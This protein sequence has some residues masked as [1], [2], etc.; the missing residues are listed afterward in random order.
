MPVAVAYPRVRQLCG[1]PLALPVASMHVAL[2]CNATLPLT[3]VTP[4]VVTPFL[5][6]I[7]YPAAPLRLRASAAA[8][9]GG[10]VGPVVPPP[11]AAP[12]KTSNSAVNPTGSPLCLND[13]TTRKYV[14]SGRPWG[15]V[16]TTAVGE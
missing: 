14:A 1:P 3:T 6:S 15:S 10:P 16:A 5:D 8:G 13:V 7:A 4:V 2:G 12:M 11:L 9:A